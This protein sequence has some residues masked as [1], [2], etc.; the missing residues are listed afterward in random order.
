M[1]NI[2][3]AVVDTAVRGLSERHEFRPDVRVLCTPA[4]YAVTTYS[5]C[6]FVRSR[7]SFMKRSGGSAGVVAPRYH[8]GDDVTLQ[9]LFLS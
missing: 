9:M 4:A 8:S 7:R 5:G 2:Q 3:P 6:T 1:I